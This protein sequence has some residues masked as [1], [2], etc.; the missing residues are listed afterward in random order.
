MKDEACGMA[1][2]S[3]EKA[4]GG[5]VEATYELAKG[6]GVN[7]PEIPREICYNKNNVQLLEKGIDR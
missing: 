4:D 3:P 5:A 1:G 6:N 2:V 7:L